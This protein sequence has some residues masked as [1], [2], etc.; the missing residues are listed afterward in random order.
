MPSLLDL[1]AI[2]SQEMR[3]QYGVVI[4]PHASASPPT[5]V[6]LTRGAVASKTRRAT[7]VCWDKSLMS[8][9]IYLLWNQSRLFW[10]T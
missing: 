7:T 5:H 1:N 4:V 9:G 8:Q 3:F 10:K 6:H 2:C